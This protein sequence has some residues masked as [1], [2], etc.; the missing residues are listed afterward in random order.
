MDGGEGGGLGGGLGLG[1]WCEMKQISAE[2]D[3]S[4]LAI[5]A[6]DSFSFQLFGGQAFK[7]ANMLTEQG[8][9]VSF[10]MKYRCPKQTIIY[11]IK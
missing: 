1:Q 10:L 2:F 11:T 9:S 5:V 8:E 3:R 7:H 6:C 4:I